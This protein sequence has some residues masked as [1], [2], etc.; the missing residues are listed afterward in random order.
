[1]NILIVGKM[2]SG[3]TAAAKYLK[4]KINNSK[5]LTL[6]GPIYEIVENLESMT[7]EEILEK[8]ISP[9]YDPRDHMATRLG[10]EISKEYIGK[11]KK[12]FADT[13]KIPIQ[14][15]K[16]RTRL[17]F[18]GTEG[19]RNNIDDNIWITIALNKARYNKNISWIIDDCRF[20]NEYDAFIKEKWKPIFLFVNKRTQ[21]KRLDLLYPDINANVLQHQSELEIDKI[22]V[23]TKCIID[24][25]QPLDNMLEDIGDLLWK[26]KI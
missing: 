12:I 6:A 23:P 3:K 22:H 16:P 9:Y 25:N 20:T 21:E 15:P 1:M 7:D 24:A 18:L 14:Y 8:Y 26:K 4:Q 11:W 2:C 5:V 17:Q 19:A 10:L 13:R